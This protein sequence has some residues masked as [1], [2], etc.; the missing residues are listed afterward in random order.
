MSILHKACV[1]NSCLYQF[2]P[3]FF[4]CMLVLVLT[5]PNDKCFLS[6]SC[7]CI[8]KYRVYSICLHN[9]GILIH[10][11]QIYICGRHVCTQLKLL[12]VFI[13]FPFSLFSYSIPTTIQV[14]LNVIILSDTQINNNWIKRGEKKERI[15]AYKQTLLYWKLIWLTQQS[16]YNH[17]NKYQEKIF[18]YSRIQI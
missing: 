12:F 8:K 10:E 6:N 17:L 2:V 7:V 13:Q 14:C 15:C 5:T 16:N 4:V 18:I 1:N 3:L 9:N 11:S